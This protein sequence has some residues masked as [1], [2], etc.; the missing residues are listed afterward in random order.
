MIQFIKAN[1]NEIRD[2]GR[3]YPWEKPC[4][5]PRCH[6]FKVWGHGFVE[7]F[8]D[9]FS[10]PLLLKRYRCPTCGCVICYRPINYFKRFQSPIQTIR[11]CIS[12]RLKTGRWRPDLSISRQG[13]WLRALKRR[14]IAFLGNSWRSKLIDAFDHLIKM[15]QIPVSRSI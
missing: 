9:G 15:G 12:C 6:D 11:D 8:F 3:D 10:S 14:V 5:C 7:A 1:L 2:K 13:H 4:K